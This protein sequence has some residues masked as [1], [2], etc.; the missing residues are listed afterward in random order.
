[1]ICISNCANYEEVL[2]LGLPYEHPCYEGL[3]VRGSCRGWP[4]LYEALLLNLSQG[5]GPELATGEMQ[6]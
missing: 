1:M 5:A 2:L 4:Y 6:G 3:K